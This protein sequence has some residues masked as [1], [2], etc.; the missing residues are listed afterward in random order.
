M[1]A[2]ARLTIVLI[3]VFIALDIVGL[4]NTVTSLLAGVGVIGIALGFAFQDIAANF[5]GGDPPCN[6]T[7][8]CS[9]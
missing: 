1:S 9:R 5:M 6:T 7:A 8:L 4:Q 3:G 2:T